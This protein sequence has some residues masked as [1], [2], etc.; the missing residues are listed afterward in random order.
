MVC[1]FPLLVLFA[2]N[3][4]KKLASIEYTFVDVLEN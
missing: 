3:H 1:L 2:F 4:L